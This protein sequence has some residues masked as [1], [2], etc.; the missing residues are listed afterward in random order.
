MVN[1][2]TAARGRLQNRCLAIWDIL[3]RR[4]HDG[5]TIEY[6]ELADAIGIALGPLQEGAP[7]RGIHYLCEQRRLPCLDLLVVKQGTGESGGP[8]Q[9]MP[10]DQV[11]AMRA[12]V[13]AYPWAN[14][15]RPQWGDFPR[16]R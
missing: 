5:V 2:R 4:A 12:R 11:D 6:K 15:A 7:L 10:R 1:R 14:V 8:W 9:A 13:Y 3:V 16:R